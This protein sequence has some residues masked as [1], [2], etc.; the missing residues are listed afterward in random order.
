[1]MS[2]LLIKNIANAQNAFN[3]FRAA[4]EGNAHDLKQV[5][6]IYKSLEEHLD[7]KK[8]LDIILN[9]GYFHNKE[10]DNMLLMETQKKLEQNY[11]ENMSSLNQVVLENHFN[12]ILLKI[13]DESNLPNTYKSS[14]LNQC[15]NESKLYNDHSFYFENYEKYNLQINDENI[16]NWNLFINQKNLSIIL[17]TPQFIN[18]FNELSVYNRI[19]IIQMLMKNYDI[20]QNEVNKFIKKVDTTG[21][22]DNLHDLLP[23]KFMLISGQLNT[24]IIHLYK[25]IGL[26]VGEVLKLVKLKDFEHSYAR[27]I[28]DLKKIIEQT[29]SQTKPY[30]E[31]AVKNFLTQDSSFLTHEIW[32]DFIH[33][34]D[35]KNKK[36]TQ[37]ENFLKL[38]N[39]ILSEVK[40]NLIKNNLLK[41]LVILEKDKFESIEDKPN[42][43]KKIKI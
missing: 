38:T 13:L 23:E 24:N 16:G 35:F 40:N 29:N 33:L 36:N 6:Q 5:E 22:I 18:D 3:L 21:F 4:L 28:K 14:I 26:D 15:I 17:N 39:S 8:M 42:Q 2:E 37:Q 20:K 19:H 34:V 30:G 32:L 1:M 27:H 12:I 41:A 9:T 31:I 43:N 10:L 7:I 11:Q 25:K